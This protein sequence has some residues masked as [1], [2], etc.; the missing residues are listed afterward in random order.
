LKIRLREFQPWIFAA[1][2][3][4]AAKQ[5]AHRAELFFTRPNRGESIRFFR[6][7]NFSLVNDGGAKS[8]GCA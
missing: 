3:P 5:P 1:E 6:M 7:K 8:P 4:P 2:F